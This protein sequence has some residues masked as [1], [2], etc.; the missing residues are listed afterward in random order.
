[1]AATKARGNTLPRRFE[2]YQRQADTQTE[3]RY[4]AQETGLKSIFD[5]LTS[6][7]TRQADAQRTMG[8][9]LL[10]SLNTAGQDLTH[11]YSEAG[12]TPE[13]L[14]GIGNNP[15]GERIASELA[16]AQAGILEQKT[17]ALAGQQYIQGDLAD[18]YREDVGEINTQAQALARE[19]GLYESSLLEQLIGEDRSRRHDANAAAAKMEFDAEQA[20]LDRDAAQ[21]NALIGQGLIP[22]AKGNLQP[23][24]GG[25]ADPNAPGNQPKPK[26]PSKPTGA[27]RSIQGDMR[28][29]ASWIKQ[30]DSANKGS[31]P[32]PA[33]RRQVVQEILLKGDQATGIPSI[34]S[35]GLD[36]ALDVFYDQALS[37]ATVQALHNAGVKVK[38]LGGA[39]TQAQLREERRK[40][41]MDQRRGKAKSRN[42]Q[43]G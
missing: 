13:V 30:L 42:Q 19:K 27:D 11:T 16:R 34:T 36:A 5:R 15:G 3:I 43:P 39:K 6:D 40:L 7:Y 18:K 33:K 9:S 2:P 26:K 25:K 4:G 24:P 14:A 37:S 38:F 22:D 28:Q 41:P 21:G 10:G 23:L 12:L 31:F 1:M 29:A 20:I 8:M 35:A 32:D 17:G